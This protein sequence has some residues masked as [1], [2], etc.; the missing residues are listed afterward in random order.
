MIW[1]LVLLHHTVLCVLHGS[2]SYVCGMQYG[3]LWQA[4]LRCMIL[5]VEGG[6][7]ASCMGLHSRHKTTTSITNTWTSQRSIRHYSWPRQTSHV[8]N[9][10]TMVQNL[11]AEA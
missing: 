10:P 7:T 9:E 2:Y 4:T 6:S 8:C 5:A 3:F 11:S 1:W